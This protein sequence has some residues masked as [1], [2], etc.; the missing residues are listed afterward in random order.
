[1]SVAH[2]EAAMRTG[3]RRPRRASEAG[4]TRSAAAPSQMPAESRMLIGSETIGEAMKS[5]A[6]I[7]CRYMARGLRA[8]LRWLFT[9]KGAK[10]S[11]RALCSCM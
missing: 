7:S 4:A 8:A 10:S 11:W 2:V 3:G 9:E 5:S 1:M 6:V